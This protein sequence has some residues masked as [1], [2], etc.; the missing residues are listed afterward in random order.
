[1]TLAQLRRV[2]S[3]G[4]ALL[5]TACTSDAETEETTLP[6]MEAAPPAPNAMARA[7]AGGG[8]VF[9][10]RPSE[11][12][13][14]QGAWT[15]AVDGADYVFTTL[16]RGPWDIPALTTFIQGMRQAAASA[17]DSLAETPVL[18]RIPPLHESDP[19]TARVR[20]R[21]ALAAGVAGIIFPHVVSRA[22]IE[23]ALGLLG[24]DGWPRNPNGPVVAVH[25]IEDRASVE[26][27]RELVG[28]PGVKVIFLGPMS[29]T[30]AFEGDSVAVEN[31]IQSVLAVCK[32]TDVACGITAGA[33]DVAE[34]VRQGFRFLV[35]REPGVLAAGRAALGR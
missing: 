28:T 31:A 8:T 3:I 10:I 17:P 20:V 2:R 16:E 9:V 1:M 32:E 7:L 18:L 12:T 13:A 27:A 15:A 29:L 19:D 22:E 25:M 23:Q 6:A 11:L 4:L 14:E 21:E 26:N 24:E 30:T 34:R 5:A 33:E 35:V